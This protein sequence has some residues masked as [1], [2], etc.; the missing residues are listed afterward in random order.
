MYDFRQACMGQTQ[1][2]TILVYDKPYTNLP[3]IG[4]NHHGGFLVVIPFAFRL[5]RPIKFS[6]EKLSRFSSL[7][8]YMICGIIIYKGHE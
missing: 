5:C 3:N 7:N 2:I 6:G 1:A 8:I 4:S